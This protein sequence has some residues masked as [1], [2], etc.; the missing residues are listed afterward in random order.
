M[1]PERTLAGAAARAGF[2]LLELLIVIAILAV[3]VSMVLPN[4]VGSRKQANEAAAIS[5]MRS[6]IGAQELYMQRYGL[7]A[8]AD[9]QLVAAGL[10]P[11]GG[12]KHGYRFSLDN[13][14]NSL[15]D[16]WGRGDPIEPGRSGDRYFFIDATGVIRATTTGRASRSS[17]PV[18]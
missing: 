3:L 11:G 17:P 9:D 15:Y 12:D 14:P 4:F 5:Y 1:A 13:P 18:R 7:Y 16:W 2:T 6:W 10:I 8:D